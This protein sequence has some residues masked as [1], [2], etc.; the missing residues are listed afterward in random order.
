LIDNTHAPRH[1][2]PTMDGRPSPMSPYRERRLWLT[3]KMIKDDHAVTKVVLIIAAV[4]TIAATGVTL[5]YSLLF[6]LAS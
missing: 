2:G 4:A 5:A 3:D 1:T 6:N